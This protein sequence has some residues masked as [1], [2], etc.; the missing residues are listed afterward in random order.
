MHFIEI[1]TVLYRSFIGQ[2]NIN[3]TLSSN[4]SVTLNNNFIFK[5][6]LQ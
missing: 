3:I 1:N 2:L 5:G 4:E 6:Y